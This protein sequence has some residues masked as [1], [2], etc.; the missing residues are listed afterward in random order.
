VRGCGWRVLGAAVAVSQICVIS[1]TYNE[2][3]DQIRTNSNLDLENVLNDLDTNDQNSTTNKLLNKCMYYTPDSIK[4]MNTYNNKS[5]I[6]T[7]EKFSLFSLNC[8][9]L[10]AHWDAFKNL[11]CQFGNSGLNPDIIGITEVFKTP[12]NINLH[13]EGYKPLITNTRP[14]ENDNRGGVGMYIKDNI[15]STLRPDLSIFI[16]HVIETLF[17]EINC[18]ITNKQTIIGSIYRPN[19]PPLANINVF[20][21]N[22]YSIIELIEKENKSCFLMGD[23]N[24]D[25]LKINTHYTTKLFVDTMFAYGLTPHITKPTRITEHSAT[26]IDNIFSNNITNENSESGIIVTDVA[27]HFGVLHIMNKVKKHKQSNSYKE[28][29]PLTDLNINAFKELLKCTDF[30]DVL[31]IDNPDEAYE[32]YLSKFKDAYNIA[33]PLKKIK[34]SNKYIKAEPWM[35]NGILTSSIRKTKL[36]HKKLKHP[37][38]ENVV[39]YKNYCKMYNKILR[40]AKRSYY[41]SSLT[42]NKNNIKLSW[43]ILNHAINRKNTKL[44]PPDSITVRDVK[45]SDKQQMANEFNSYF[46]NIANLVCEQIPP[47]RSNYKDF[48][49]GTHNKSF[50]LHP[51]IPEDIISIAKHMKGKK[52]VGHDNISTLLMKS[53]IEYTAKPLAHIFNHSFTE[54][55]IPLK[56]KTAKIVPVY[57]KGNHDN[58]NNYRP[59]S[60]LPAYS[61]LL[62]KIVCKQLTSFL[63]KENILYEHQ[64][65]FRP[66]H[67][68]IHPISHLLY[69]ISQA[70]DKKEITLAT[71]LDLSKAFDTI[72]HEILLTKLQHYGIRGIN[73]DWFRNYLSN[74]TQYTEIDACKSSEKYISH[75]VPQGSILG[76]ILFLVYINDISH[77]TT[78]KLL[79][80][81][82]DTAVYTSSKDLKQLFARLNNELDK[83]NDWFRAN[84]LSLNTNKTNYMVF[85]PSKTPNHTH[86]IIIDNQVIEQIGNNKN[87][88]TVKFLGIHLDENLTWKKHISAIATKISRSLYA[89]NRAKKF[90]PFTA[91]KLL[92]L[93]L[94]QSNI[95]YGIM[96]WGNSLHTKQLQLMQK[97]AIRI[98]CNKPYKAHTDPLFKHCK[99]LKI[100][101]I[102]NVSTSLFMHDYVHNPDRLPNSFKNIYKMTCNQIVTRQK[103]SIK[104]TKPRTNFSERLTKHSLPIVWNRLD[105]NLKQLHKRG[106]FKKT[107]TSKLLSEYTE[108]VVCN[109][110]ACT[111]CFADNM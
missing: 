104:R 45:I 6:H 78:L 79:S 19:S 97:K 11:L 92:Y 20:L 2:L 67:A 31:L 95:Q 24:I 33:F 83:L 110:V 63:T 3:I 37:S 85:S 27:D 82:D 32:C 66:N 7:S 109:N 41:V 29:R 49:T 47:S 43:N 13:I 77:S 88:D 16:P 108:V 40:R 44:G 26:L 5:D 50:F 54:G 4:N 86:N 70:D 111:E 74:R 57:K 90:L 71:F 52:S 39:N 73:N 80:Y 84:K 93:A 105:D 42:E 8:Q 28:I 18:P 75:G 15:I 99:L 56:L 94:I 65:G 23:F 62:E 30:S 46:S 22:L 100:G 25:M 35:T 96:A 89:I 91:L 76:P 81:A 9:S 21:E 10:K 69:D 107:I 51:V 48:L 36:L 59:I 38:E 64:Y 101:D 14:N 87:I 106:E 68:T 55:I 58:L 1:F 102:Y 17:V 34:L 61:K 103:L 72:N 98:I 12:P 60:L 53:T